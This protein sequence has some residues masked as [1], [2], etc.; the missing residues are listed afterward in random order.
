MRTPYGTASEF[1]SPNHDLLA[2]PRPHLLDSPAI[3]QGVATAVL[4]ATLSSGKITVLVVDEEVRDLYGGWVHCV[5]LRVDGCTLH[6]G[7]L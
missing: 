6:G 2:Q 7:N 1:S 4:M 5:G 3:I